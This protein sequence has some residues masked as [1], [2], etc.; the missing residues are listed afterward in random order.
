METVCFFLVCKRNPRGTQTQK[1]YI[2]VFASCQ[3]N[4]TI[5]TTTKKINPTGNNTL[6]IRVRGPLLRSLLCLPIAADVSGDNTGR[7]HCKQQTALTRR[8]NKHKQEQTNKQKQKRTVQGLS[9]AA[10]HVNVAAGPCGRAVIATCNSDGA[11]VVH[12]GHLT[13]HRKTE[14]QTMRTKQ[15]QQHNT[16]THS[17]AHAASAEA[18]CADAVRG[19]A[20]TTGAVGGMTAAAAALTA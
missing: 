16:S 1:F 4:H 10:V 15:T 9:G 3:Q 17:A 7:D 19:T 14:S 12:V 6:T 18:C 2:S 11:A 8:T 13:R 5:P 20:G